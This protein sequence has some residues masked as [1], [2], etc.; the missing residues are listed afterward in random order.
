MRG[1]PQIRFWSCKDPKKFTDWTRRLNRK[2]FK[3]NKHTKVCSN[4]FELGSPV[5]SHPNP[6]LFLKGY[7]H[8]DQVKSK[9]K[10]PLVMSPEEPKVKKKRKPSDENNKN[11]KC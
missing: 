3:V 5:D 1:K 6:T 4:H 7:D 2:N 9:R 10:A 8:S 11:G